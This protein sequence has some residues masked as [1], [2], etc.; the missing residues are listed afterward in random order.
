MAHPVV[1]I[2]GMWCTGSNWDRVAQGLRARGFVCHAPT[3]PAHADGGDAAAVAAL[4]LKDYAAFLRAYIEQQNFTQPPIL[5]GHSMGGFLAQQLA[6]EFDCFA[7]VLLTPAAPAGINGVRS[8]PLAAFARAL[9]RPGFWKRAHKP[10]F[11]RA[12]KSV[13]NGLPLA[14]QTAIYAGLVPE[15]GRALF[16][17]AFWW[18]DFGHATRI[19]ASRVRCPVYVLSAGRDAL[20]PAP[21]VRK[22]AS[23]YAGAALRHYPLRSHWVLDDDDTDD[24]VSEIAGWLLPL[25]QRAAKLVRNR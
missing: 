6:S 17:L 15:S 12:Q 3:L 24:M 22:V 14:Q 4:S 23:L 21:V 19:D 10:S 20:T 18:T 2:H 8:K 16:E 7:L 13:V 11:E 5:I 1:L 9:A 25:E